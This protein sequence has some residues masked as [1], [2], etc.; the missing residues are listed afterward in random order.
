MRENAAEIFGDLGGSLIVLTD[1]QDSCY[2]NQGLAIQTFLALAT[3]ALYL[4]YKVTTYSI[5]YSYGGSTP[6]EL[7]TIAINGGSGLRSH[8]SAGNEEEL[9]SALEGVIDRVKFCRPP[10]LER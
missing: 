2:Y 9:S 1:G 4:D 3:S 5:G 8:I 6:I 10:P 7:D